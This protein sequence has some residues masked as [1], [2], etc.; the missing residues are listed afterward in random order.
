MAT[1]VKVEGLKELEA[2]LEELGS[3]AVARGVLRRV[4][5]RRGQPL[6]DTMRAL[7]PDDPD[8]GG[9]DLRSSIAVS[10][11]LSPRQRRL[12]RKETKDDRAFAEVFVGAGPL[13]QAHLQEF[14]TS[15]HG[16]QP[17]AR[18]AWDEHK[19][20]ILDGLKDDLWKEVEKTAKRRAARAARLAA[21]G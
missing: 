8:T 16:P 9:N 11:K 6:A 2:A 18:P 20:R 7:A 3:K 15:H 19:G 5:T 12:H 14:G 4:L 1:R 10:T 17:F 21:K 13:P